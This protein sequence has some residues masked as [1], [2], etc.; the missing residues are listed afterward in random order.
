MMITT[1]ELQLSFHVSATASV[2][3]FSHI[4]DTVIKTFKFRNKL[5]HKKIIQG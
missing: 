4:S 1:K 5:M 3:T 2:I